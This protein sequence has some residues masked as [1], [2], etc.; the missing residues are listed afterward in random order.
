VPKDNSDN[1]NGIPVERQGRK[2][3][4]L[5]AWP[6]VTGERMI[7]GLP[8]DPNSSL[9]DIQKMSTWA[10]FGFGGA[11]VEGIIGLIYQELN[12]EAV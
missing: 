5:S 7:A 8:H 1:R 12:H 2:V 4:G 11:H 10:A 3:T 6:V 9:L